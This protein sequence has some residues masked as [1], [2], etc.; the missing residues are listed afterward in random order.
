V[1]LA[2]IPDRGTRRYLLQ[3]GGNV[4]RTLK[5]HGP[6]TDAGNWK[7]V[8][9]LL[10]PV[11]DDDLPGP[12]RDRRSYRF[13][14]VGWES[15]VAAYRLYLDGRNAVD[16][17]GK[18]RPGLY[19]N[20]IG[21]SGIDYQLDADWGMDVLHVGP[22]L[23]VGG[24]GFWE[25]DSVRKPLEV[26]RQRCR[27]IARGPVRAVVEVAYTGWKTAAGAVNVTSRFTI[28]AGDRVTEHR[29]RISPE[30]PMPTLATG[31][32]RHDSTTVLSDPGGRWI[33]TAGL[34][35][36]AGD[37]LMLAVV[38]PRGSFVRSTMD[39]VNHLLL[40]RPDQRGELRFLIASLWEGEAETMW[41]REELT[42][43][44]E[45]MSARLEEPLGV[46]LVTELR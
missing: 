34:Q 11:D 46:E 7:R 22:A 27:I 5:I 13:D 36:R 15:E 35:S 39:S 30:G 12:E 23:G 32:V 42:V 3:S 25:G 6:R 45:S 41:S 8:G 26:A 14:G 33:A 28:S 17:Q 19:W 31:I 20:W 16:V 44:L 21:A 4:E 29:V 10:Q 18:R 40:L 24:I 1:F 38:V 2:D 37:S 43:F 9:G